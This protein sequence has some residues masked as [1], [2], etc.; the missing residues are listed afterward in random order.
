MEE[1][2]GEISKEFSIADLEKQSEYV[3]WALSRIIFLMF[4][5][6]AY[7]SVGGDISKNVQKVT[8]N[9]AT[10]LE[11]SLAPSSAMNTQMKRMPTD[12]EGVDLSQTP[13]LNKVATSNQSA[14]GVNWITSKSLQRKIAQRMQLSK[15]RNNLKSKKII[16][17][18]KI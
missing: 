6:M 8:A 11:T 13:V 15:S 5:M 18:R 12:N 9:P 4:V 7:Q 3:D 14:T 17:Y 2:S 16:N 1:F 10:F